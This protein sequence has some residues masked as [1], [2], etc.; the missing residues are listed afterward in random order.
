MGEPSV[1]NSFFFTLLTHTHVLELG[2]TY[3][4][5]VFMKSAADFENA[6]SY[7]FTNV[8]IQALER[9]PDLLAGTRADLE[10]VQSSD[11][12]FTLTVA[13]DD[14]GL[15]NLA[16]DTAY[17]VRFEETYTYENTGSDAAVATLTSKEPD[18]DNAD[19]VTLTFT[20]T[21]ADD[22]E[23]VYIIANDVPQ[24]KVQE[25]ESLVATPLDVNEAPHTITLGG[26]T[27]STRSVAENVSNADLG[28][29]GVTDPDA[30]DTVTFSIAAGGNGASFALETSEDGTRL[31][32]PLAQDY[33]ALTEQG[34]TNS[35]SVTVNATDGEFTIS[36]AF[37]VT[38]TNVDHSES[39]PQLSSSTVNVLKTAFVG[40]L[41]AAA[42]NTFEI[43]SASDSASADSD[44]FEIETVGNPAVHKLKLTE[45]AR[46]AQIAN[47][48]ATLTVRVR[49]K[50][51]NA[52]ESVPSDWVDFV[53]TIDT[54]NSAPFDLKL[55]D[56]TAPVTV[57][58]HDD[59]NLVV[60]VL[61]AYNYEKGDSITF[62][63]DEASQAR[64]EL[65]NDA[66]T[67]E[68]SISP[69]TDDQP[70]K[71]KHTQ[72][73]KLKAALDFEA[74]DPPSYSVGVTATDAT[75]NAITQTFTVTLLDGLIT[76]RT[77]DVDEKAP[78]AVVG[79]LRYK[80]QDMGANFALHTM[81]DTF[82]IVGTVTDDMAVTRIAAL[83]DADGAIQ[84][85]EVR[86]KT[87]SL[88]WTDAAD[89]TAEATR[90][91]AKAVA[92]PSLALAPAITTQAATEDAPAE[93]HLPRT[94]MSDHFPA[95][96]AQY[97]MLLNANDYLDST[98]IASYGHAESVVRTVAENGE[99]ASLS[100]GGGLAGLEATAT[101]A[102]T[103]ALT[104]GKQY[105]LGFDV[106][107]LF[108]AAGAKYRFGDTSAAALSAWKMQL[109]A[110]TGIGMSLINILVE[111]DSDAFWERCRFEIAQDLLAAHGYENLFQDAAAQTA[112]S[113]TAIFPELEAN[114][115]IVYIRFTTD[116]AETISAATVGG[117]SVLQLKR[118]G[119]V[120]R[121][122]TPTWSIEPVANQRFELGVASGPQLPAGAGVLATF[123]PPAAAVAEWKSL[124]PVDYARSEGGR[125]VFTAAP[126]SALPTG[127]LGQLEVRERAFP[128]TN[129][130]TLG[131]QEYV[132]AV[133]YAAN[134]SALAYLRITTN[135][136]S[137]SLTIGT[138]PAD[139]TE[140]NSL[141]I[142]TGQM[143]TGFST[144]VAFPALEA[145]T[146]DTFGA[147][148]KLIKGTELVYSGP[149][150]SYTLRVSA[151]DIDDGVQHFE[152][153]TVGVN[154]VNQA[155]NVLKL[156]N[157]TIGFVKTGRI[158]ALVG[159]FR[160]TD[161]DATVI[162]ADASYSTLTYSLVAG[163]EDNDKF[164]IED[165]ASGY[166][167]LTNGKL[168][169]DAGTELT[170][171]ARVTDGG[172]L[173]LEQVLT[174]TVEAL[175]P[176]TDPE[177]AHL[178][179]EKPTNITI[180]PGSNVILAPV[181]VVGHEVATL[182]MGPSD[183]PDLAQ[184]GT[185]NALPGGDSHT[186]SIRNDDPTKEVM[187]EI[188]GDKLKT[189]KTLGYSQY[190]VKVRVTDKA[191]NTYDKEIVVRAYR[192][193]TVAIAAPSADQ[194]GGFAHTRKPQTVTATVDHALES[195][196]YAVTLT[197][198]TIDPG[199]ADEVNVPTNATTTYDLSGINEISLTMRNDYWVQYVDG[200][201]TSAFEE[202]AHAVERFDHIPGS[203]VDEKAQTIT[204][205]RFTFK[206]VK[207]GTDIIT[208]VDNDDAAYISED[209]SS[210]V[211]PNVSLSKYGGHKFRFS[212]EQGSGSSNSVSFEAD[213]TVALDRQQTLE[214]ELIAVEE[215]LEKHHGLDIKLITD[216][217][218]EGEHTGLD[219]AK[220]IEKI[221]VDRTTAREEFI[222]ALLALDADKTDGASITIATD[223][224][225]A[226]IVSAMETYIAAEL[227]VLKGISGV[228][229]AE[230][231][232]L[233]G[234]TLKTKVLEAVAATERNSIA[235]ALQGLDWIDSVDASSASSA[236][237]LATKVQTV[238]NR[239]EA[240]FTTE[241]GEI[242]GVAV[243]DYAITVAGENA[244]D[245]GTS[246]TAQ[247]Q[248]VL[249]ARKAAVAED[250]RDAIR[251]AGIETVAETGIEAT[252]IEADVKEA[253]DNR[254]VEVA[255]ALNALT[256]KDNAGN[257]LLDANGAPIHPF[258][259]ATDSDS[260]S[261]SAFITNLQTA[262][263]AAKDAEAD[264][265]R[266]ALATQI[267][268]DADIAALFDAGATAAVAAADAGDET[269]ALPDLTLTGAT[270][271]DD[272]S[273]SGTYVP[274]T[275]EDGQYAYFADQKMHYNNYYDASLGYGVWN[276]A[277]VYIKNDF[278][279]EYLNNPDGGINGAYLYWAVRPRSTPP[280]VDD[281]S[282][283]RWEFAL[284]NPSTGG[285]S[286]GNA[287][288]YGVGGDRSS[289]LTV[290]SWVGQKYGYE[291]DTQIT[292]AGPA[293][294]PFNGTDSQWVTDI[295]DA[296]T[297]ARAAERGV[298]ATELKGVRGA[299]DADAEIVSIGD[300]PSAADIHD[301]VQSAV[302]LLR[303]EVAT[304]LH[305]VA[306]LQV[307][308]A[309]ELATIAAN[310]AA[311]VVKSAAEIKAAVET[312]K[313]GP[314]G[315]I[316]SAITD[317]KEEF[318]G[319]LT[320]ASANA[321]VPT[322]TIASGTVTSDSEWSA[323]ADAI[324][325]AAG[326]AVTARRGVLVTRL[327]E[328]N[329]LTNHPQTGN[330]VDISDM[331][332]DQI[333]TKIEEMVDV[334]ELV[335]SD[336][337]R[338]ALT[339]VLRDIP[340][341]NINEEWAASPEV[342]ADLSKLTD[343]NIEER[344][345]YA[346]TRLR[347][348][349]AED[350][351]AAVNRAIEDS[352]ES[353]RTE[354]REL[355]VIVDGADDI[356]SI[357]TLIRAKRSTLAS[358]LNAIE[359]IR[360]DPL[361]APTDAQLTSSITASIEKQ[362][363]DLLDLLDPPSTPA[364]IE[365]T[366]PAAA[367]AAGDAGS[368][369]GGSSSGGYTVS[370]AYAEQR[371]IAGTYTQRA[372]LNGHPSYSNGTHTLWVDF[373]LI[374][375]LK[376]F[377][378]GWVITTNADA[379]V[380]SDRQQIN[381][382]VGR[383]NAQLARRRDDVAT[384]DEDPGDNGWIRISGTAVDMSVTAA[385][386]DAS[387]G[388]SSGS[389]EIIFASQTSGTD[390]HTSAAHGWQEV[391]IPGNTQ[392]I[393]SISLN[394]GQYGAIQ[395]LWKLEVYTTAAA[396]YSTVNSK[397]NNHPV[398]ATSQAT[399]AAYPFTAA[400]TTLTEFVFDVPFTAERFW[401]VVRPE[402]S[403]LYN[404]HIWG[405]SG[406]SEG[407]AGSQGA[408]TMNYVVKGDARDAADAGD[409]T[410]ALPDLTLTGATGSDDTSISGTYVPYTSEDGQYA[411]FADQKMHYNNYYDASLGYGVW[412]GAP[413]YIKN[414][415]TGEYLNNP[416]G[417]INGAYLYWAV[418]P[419]STPPGVDDTS[420]GRWEFAL[421][422]PSTGGRSDGN[423]LIYGVGGDR[424][425]PLTVTSWV[426]QKYGYEDDTQITLAGPPMQYVVG[427]ELQGDVALARGTAYT[428]SYPANHPLALS[429][430]QD[431][432]HG[433]GVEYT[434]GVVRNENNQ[435]TVTLPY[436]TPDALYYY[437]AQHAGM[438]GAINVGG[439]AGLTISRAT[440]T[441]ARDDAN[442]F[443]QLQ[444]AVRAAS[445]VA[446]EDVV[447]YL[448]QHSAE[449]GV[450]FADTAGDSADFLADLKAAFAAQR[451]LML[452]KLA[453]A[454][455]HIAVAVAA[456][457]NSKSATL[458]AVVAEV[459]RAFHTKREALVE[460][461]DEVVD[462]VPTGDA[463]HDDDALKNAIAATLVR[464]RKDLL[465]M[466]VGVNAETGE[467][468]VPG[469]TIDEALE[470][471]TAQAAI[472]AAL[473]AHYNSKRGTL[474]GE[475]I[476]TLARIDDFTV[477]LDGVPDDAVVT[478]AV[479]DALL[480]QR[481][482]LVGALNNIEEKYSGTSDEFAIAI[483]GDVLNNSNVVGEIG[484]ALE[485]QRETLRETLDAIDG[486]DL[487]KTNAGS[488]ALVAE[489]AAYI[490]SGAFADSTGIA[491]TYN[492]QEGADNT[493][494]NAEGYPDMSVAAVT[495]VANTVVTGDVN[496]TL[497]V[498]GLGADLDGSYTFDPV[499][500]GIGDGKPHYVNHGDFDVWLVY[501]S[502]SHISSRPS[503]Q[504]LTP[505]WC[506]VN[507]A[508]NYHDQLKA[509]ATRQDTDFPTQVTEWRVVGGAVVTAPA[510]V[511]YTVS[512]V[513]AEMEG[514]AGT[515][516]QRADVNG[517]PSY[518]NGTHTLW[519]YEN[520]WCW[521]IT[522]VANV[523]AS[524]TTHLLA[525]SRTL[526][527]PDTNPA[528]QEWSHSY[529]VL[530]TVTGDV[531][532][533]LVVAG[534]RADLDGSYTK[535]TSLT[536]SKRIY[537]ST[538]SSIK[539]VYITAS[540]AQNL[541]FP[542]I[543][544][545][546]CFID[547]SS[548]P[549]A[550]KAHATRQDTDF[551][552][553][554][555]EW[556]V[557]GHIDMSVAPATGTVAYAVSGAYAEQ[558]GFAG[559]YVREPGHDTVYMYNQFAIWFD[560]DQGLWFIG[561]AEGIGNPG[562]TLAHKAHNT[563]DAPLPGEHSKE[564]SNG[565]HTIW[566]ESN[567]TNSWVITTNEG[568]RQLGPPLALAHTLDGNAWED[569][570]MMPVDMV[571]TDAALASN[572]PP[573]SPISDAAFEAAVLKAIDDSRVGLRNAM[574]DIVSIPAGS[575]TDEAFA[576][577]VRT[578]VE[579]IRADAAAD[580]AAKQAELTAKEQELAAA[581]LAHA[582]A[583]AAEQNWYVGQLESAQLAH[584]AA[585]ADLAQAK[586]M[587]HTNALT[588]HVRVLKQ[589]MADRGYTID[590]TP[591]GSVDVDAQLYQVAH[592]ALLEQRRVLVESLQAEPLR[593]TVADSTDIVGAVQ[594]AL[595]KQRQAF[596]QSL[597]SIAGI[598]ITVPPASNAPAVLD[599]IKSEIAQRFVEQRDV[600]LESIGDIPGI[601]VDPNLISTASE[602]RVSSAE[603]SAAANA[604]VAAVR[605]GLLTLRA[606]IIT[607]LNDVPGV[608]VDIANAAVL[609]DTEQTT[610]EDYTAALVANIGDKLEKSLEN[611]VGE[612]NSISIDNFEGQPVQVQITSL[613][614]L[615]SNTGEPTTLAQRYDNIRGAIRTALNDQK[616]ENKKAQRAELVAKLNSIKFERADG[617]PYYPIVIS[618]A[619][620][621]GAMDVERVHDAVESALELERRDIAD[622]VTSA[623]ED[624]RN[625]L[626]D[627]V[628]HGEIP[629]NAA[630]KA[631][632]KEG[633][634]QKRERLA[635]DL[636]ANCGVPRTELIAEDG[637]YTDAG[638]RAGVTKAVENATVAQRKSVTDALNAIHGIDIAAN[639]NE[640]AIASAVSGY[641]TDFLDHLHNS[642][643]TIKFSLGTTNWLEE[644]GYVLQQRTPGTN[645]WVNV[646][647]DPVE[648]ST[649]KD[650]TDGTETVF[651]SF[652]AVLAAGENVRM[653]NTKWNTWVNVQ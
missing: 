269:G 169:D 210:I 255:E 211:I 380:F 136:S 446:R 263:D 19:K 171:R 627:M 159:Y 476:N 228:T 320:D 538:H 630:I 527:T 261:S 143:L 583:L 396:G 552:T 433:G 208:G 377:P 63:L 628:P 161:P 232:T 250:F 585:L 297:A 401:F 431:G 392:P 251:A 66:D 613:P 41:S 348:K 594:L 39:V 234:A 455:V 511:A 491:G 219:M 452:T 648:T 423:A 492:V 156:G 80:D 101:D 224:S 49:T 436:H 624:I 505:G 178:Y 231:E 326:N 55:D 606:D 209:R 550:L 536:N 94:S 190:S 200:M 358:M 334:A 317:T 644:D 299:D 225:D 478:K 76:P 482:D 310:P 533:T 437:C 621:A 471:E 568:K 487:P 158:D 296:L 273:I 483:D 402:G 351:A 104:A 106:F 582:N 604:A 257:D 573:T 318:V 24:R 258:S 307:Y 276:G 3:G 608:E 523:G 91:A 449:T 569:G 179:N 434:A 371:G 645:T 375:Q 280:G 135:N 365:F 447:K 427:G 529:P 595:G 7:T 584:A 325:T 481:Q 58:E 277:P 653:Y 532:G 403:I 305:S 144:G 150:T 301:A 82:E 646:G 526:L 619:T 319:Y 356:D 26:T 37:T 288:I 459:Q 543:T 399:V 540:D 346:I 16:I 78:G 111:Y 43:Y 622:A 123:Q 242:D 173:F 379:E 90:Y 259:I 185:D 393:R 411:Y 417:G 366:A 329:V 507:I 352:V 395:G 230:G 47:P 381:N 388:S 620:Y 354:L 335:A 596:A 591:D 206:E 369:S 461:L 181:G 602:D 48:S 235:T 363:A 488:V 462:T 246:I 147:V 337:K 516:T 205:P 342:D 571:T 496:G 632:V 581:Q 501:I 578:F 546:W 283:G 236:A 290:T 212:F 281:T 153:I 86:K 157:S 486:V 647:G 419:R 498:A 167:L 315:W 473:T 229:Y 138:A 470:P 421:D 599:T 412:N 438:G 89:E 512:G 304:A 240:A 85:L 149:T 410:G 549:P 194:A 580:L 607:A 306:G 448:N 172:G 249:T 213:S 154:S 545:G 564:Y 4:Q 11:T 129:S 566:F 479:T 611:L 184:E 643:L 499:G 223:A 266:L 137:N 386:A 77:M 117:E 180:T 405:T 256:L 575:A 239:V 61:S 450:T 282:D 175:D 577:I 227:E 160:G 50:A 475:L 407:V 598:T 96:P 186:F 469:F 336:A 520:P 477:D 124:T 642:K 45:T 311:V 631:A 8:K 88:A 340:D 357:E 193:P 216:A 394:V 528:L 472:T 454:G 387:A 468:N 553:Q 121:T 1:Q 464:Q 639:A 548:S 69:A 638:V 521:V 649:H 513:H 344:I 222:D 409:E 146:D 34:G 162:G 46:S 636:V 500:I 637:F 253:L 332:D 442:I 207:T 589:A 127:P 274:Y 616:A 489:G 650:A 460:K 109:D 635:D 614:T 29:L 2:G 139:P 70:K 515:Y 397:F 31:K 164:K 119:K 18:A 343:A 100:F 485:D 35:F 530:P 113:D 221:K 83:V 57:K 535:S 87:G 303:S 497:V 67:E 519:Q 457:D 390:R 98:R 312:A 432:T 629:T 385:V 321:R 192:V 331:E 201:G 563:P 316:A 349:A 557:R 422:N 453:T 572:A 474:G 176:A 490:V 314:G 6:S 122:W 510:G 503:L 330:A 5:N 298:I 51:T 199:T 103:F 361:T 84:S 204:V 353:V 509:H 429:T 592:Q 56:G 605:A 108:S 188:S 374:T 517:Q 593:M 418:R 128:A 576:G 524:G 634:R 384:P 163:A 373:T 539:I 93:L 10:Y 166:A 248:G 28:V 183:D 494:M 350:Q 623:D 148:L 333:A 408:M 347:N 300:N 54:T 270:G 110:K 174:I 126:G 102:N 217:N 14:A 466:L 324:E 74:E 245:R 600:I 551:P 506:F 579:G 64:F 323:I 626:L 243:A 25:I 62:T 484:N 444:N 610:R 38:I 451:S 33:E 370:G 625:R 112:Y 362:R 115:G 565:T 327:G 441:E 226:E 651:V 531:N 416:D 640:T 302:S 367:P 170:V 278:T 279:G 428:I 81:D 425:S 284:D 120:V 597:N 23:G 413:V 97:P 618:D 309:E 15:A 68:E 391:N 73:L 609:A 567:V 633:I 189:T 292:L 360:V 268:G 612:L 426:G 355:G 338:T 420:D 389:Q 586:S 378:P 262:V 202:L 260:V 114:D 267:R 558:G 59:D 542:A 445:N 52:Q 130:I 60:G 187:F 133:E 372:D 652:D 254:R 424:S 588:E 195:G 92:M 20:G 238:L 141:N 641:A 382:V 313:D 134:A 440:P 615:D 247:V 155:P 220:M 534:L 502:A 285:R 508:R 53:I 465:A 197:G 118:D 603:A 271:S 177:A 142:P 339:T 165:H 152:Q 252:N 547:V 233:N 587:A 341:L 525:E 291:D 294:T 12:Q 272:T 590:V 203:T 295:T 264:A 182:S 99:E 435:L 151:T 107:A 275:S 537:D 560:G 13:Q 308:T 214:F 328:I 522:T 140:L 368:S 345:E 132:T 27:D 554:V 42:N 191:N 415:F 398:I 518:S 414:D 32:M 79:Q 40:L 541:N 406:G 286:D 359:G 95:D 601:E 556:R 21:A 480:K 131:P 562:M 218:P 237:N 75:D 463:I 430:T 555:P 559:T 293:V 383:M 544:P 22:P 561:H 244:A 504:G 215:A 456:D 145:S 198:V 322:L 458:D 116:G 439:I 241:L 44:Q 265:R 514:F 125:H 9:L 71:Y 617:T 196:N 376:T 36:K 404:L 72:T 65:A 570:D 30:G 467:P 495:G 17:K 400:E 364:A 289:P 168:S 493:W 443:A 574:S 287:L 105:T